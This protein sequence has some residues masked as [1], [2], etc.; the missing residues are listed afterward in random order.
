MLKVLEKYL[1]SF[2]RHE[3]ES[4]I[5]GNLCTRYRFSDRLNDFAKENLF[6]SENFWGAIFPLLS[7]NRHRT[8]LNRT[9][10]WKE[11]WKEEWK[12]SESILRCLRGTERCNLS[13]S[14]EIK[15]FKAVY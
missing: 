6:A 1:I 15:Y 8:R 13:P 12:D 10:V 9:E 11:V 7:Y 2:V 4:L 14:M 5:F 3:N